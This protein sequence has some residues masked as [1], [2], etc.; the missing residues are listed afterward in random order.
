MFPKTSLWNPQFLEKLSRIEKSEEGSLFSLVD[1]S[2][3]SQ[4]FEKGRLL[5]E[6]CS[7]WQKRQREH[8]RW[9]GH[10]SAFKRAVWRCNPLRSPKLGSG[11][12]HSPSPTP[13]FD[14]GGASLIDQLV[15]N[16]PAMQETW[17]RFLGQEDPL[18]KEMA[19]CSSILALRIPWT[20]EPG[21]LQSMGL[22]ESD[23]T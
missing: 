4:P 7:S 15:K 21:S 8:G 12:I 23:M 22:Q 20:E 1:K 19:T 5:R 3:N 10:R 6:G 17:V 9:D 16:L 18:E 2:K 13:S 14:M 11:I